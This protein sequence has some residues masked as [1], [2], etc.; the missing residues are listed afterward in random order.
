MTPVSQIAQQLNRSL[1]AIY[2]EI[3]RGEVEL[4]RSDLTSYTSYSADVAQQKHD[5]AQTSKGRP[6]KI[7]NDHAFA[8]F[9]SDKIIKEHYS[10]ASA[11]AAAR[12]EGFQTDLSVNTLYSYVVPHPGH[13]D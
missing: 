1:S 5:Y 4:L 13:V 8:D 9:V 6:L 7:G 3:K 2:K 10:P 12:R 11:L